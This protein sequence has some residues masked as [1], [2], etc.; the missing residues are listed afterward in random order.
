MMKKAIPNPITRKSKTIR[1]YFI[2]L[3]I[4]MSIATTTAVHRNILRK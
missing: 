2:S 4:S 3:K 1:K